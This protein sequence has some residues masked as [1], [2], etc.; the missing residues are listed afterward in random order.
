MQTE[1]AFAFLRPVDFDSLKPIADTGKMAVQRVLDCD[2]GARTCQVT[3]FIHAPGQASPA[4][5][6]THDF[7]K[8]IFVVEGTESVQIEDQLFEANAGD[9]IVF[10]AGVRH[11]NWNA[12][13]E[14][15]KLL[16]FITPLP[17]PERPISNPV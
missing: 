4:G 11:R 16:S 2:S 15:V 7:D 17:D 5:L 9:C 14:Y 8:V 3:A 6:H 10:P 13:N 12:T 1:A